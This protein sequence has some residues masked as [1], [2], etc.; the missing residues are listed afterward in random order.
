MS[1]LILDC[2]KD[3]HWLYRRKLLSLTRD[4]TCVDSVEKCKEEIKD[5]DYSLVLLRHEIT[6]SSG[7]QV[8]E[9]LRSSGY[10]GKVAII[11]SG[12]G[13]EW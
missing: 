2:N 11:A 3:S 1:I 5:N 12:N 4:I 9:D 8:Y 10:Q 6:N 13:L 7:K